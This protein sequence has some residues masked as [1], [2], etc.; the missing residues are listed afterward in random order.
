MRVPSHPTY[1]LR[2]LQGPPQEAGH[3]LAH[4]GGDARLWDE[5]HRLGPRRGSPLVVVRMTLNR[6]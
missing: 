1:L 6:L 4:R 3:L 2:M 5:G